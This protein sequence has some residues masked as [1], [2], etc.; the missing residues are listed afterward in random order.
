LNRQYPYYDS[1]LARILGVFIAIQCC[2]SSATGRTIETADDTMTN[3]M[4]ISGRDTHGKKIPHNE[5]VLLKVPDMLKSL[6]K[7]ACQLDGST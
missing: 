6:G 4:P 5:W 2:P 7:D 3:L 1:A